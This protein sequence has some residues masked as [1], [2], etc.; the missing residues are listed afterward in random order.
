MKNLLRALAALLTVVTTS[1]HGGQPPPRKL[2]I[3]FCQQLVPDSVQQGNWSE[4]LTYSVQTNSNGK[5]IGVTRR[6]DSQFPDRAVVDCMKSWTL[7]IHS[8]TTTAMWR[9]Q[10]GQ[11]WTSLSIASVSDAWK[12]TLNPGGDS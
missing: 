5:V 2:E 8:A 10:H 7:P 9:W 3:V 6:R 1:S 11:G 12:L 4:S